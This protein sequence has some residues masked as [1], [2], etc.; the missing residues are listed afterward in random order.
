MDDQATIR[1]L[2][3]RTER[4]IAVWGRF[5]ERLAHWLQGWTILVVL[6]FAAK[7]WIAEIP[8]FALAALAAS[9]TAMYLWLLFVNAHRWRLEFRRRDLEKKVDVS[10]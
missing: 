5:E 10:Q 8:W 9:H 2:Y 7:I 3:F 1:S 4:R 6:G